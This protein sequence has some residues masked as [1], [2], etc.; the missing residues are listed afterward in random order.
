MLAFSELNQKYVC[1]KRDLLKRALF[2]QLYMA[3]ASTA[4]CLFMNESKITR[5]KVCVDTC[6]TSGTNE[7]WTQQ[8]FYPK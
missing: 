7:V 4:V 3:F 1:Q 6:Q 5:V 8:Y 2:Q